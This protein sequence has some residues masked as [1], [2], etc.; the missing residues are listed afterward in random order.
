MK[1]VM[2]NEGHKSTSICSVT[3]WKFTYL[4]LKIFMYLFLERGE[5]TWPKTQAHALTGDQTSYLLVRAAMLNP[6][7]HTSQGDCESFKK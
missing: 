7:S 1:P 3:V 5:G 4:F 6:L 2:L